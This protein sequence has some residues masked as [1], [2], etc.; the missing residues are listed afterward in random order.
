[1]VVQLN[2]ILKVIKERRSVRKYKPDKLPKEDLNEILEAGR[3]APSSGNTQ[4][5]ELVVV[6]DHNK[7][8]QLA[9]AAHGQSF[10]SEAPLVIVACANVP[11][12]ERRYGKRG[13][14]LYA[15]QD[16]AASI[17]NIH[18]AAKSMGYATCWIGA[19]NEKK[20][21]ETIKTPEKVKPVAIIPLGRPNENPKPPKRRGLQEIIHK[22]TY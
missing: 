1:M 14:E 21:R 3:W 10:I 22:N 7:K 18:L 13:A 17:Q 16:T 15:I 12:T 8:K 4:P 11:R 6:D 5:L 20:V 19:F 2:D 9:R